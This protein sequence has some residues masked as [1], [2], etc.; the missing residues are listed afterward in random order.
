MPKEKAERQELTP[1]LRKK[2]EAIQEVQ[3]QLGAL[4]QEIGV[5]N[6]NTGKD[7]E[8]PQPITEMSVLNELQTAWSNAYLAHEGADSS[9]LKGFEKWKSF[10]Q[11]MGGEAA[12]SGIT[13]LLKALADAPSE[14]EQQATDAALRFE[15]SQLSDEMNA[16]QKYLDTFPAA[17]LSERAE[18]QVDKILG[19]LPPEAQEF[20]R[21]I[22]FDFLASIGESFNMLDFS[23]SLRF[24]MAM[25]QA[26]GDT[27]SLEKLKPEEREEVLKASVD[28]VVRSGLESKWKAEHRRWVQ[29]RKVFESNNPGKKYVV[30]PPTIFDVYKKPEPSKP[31]AESALAGN[32]KPSEVSSPAKDQTPPVNPPPPKA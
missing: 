14:K 5:R 11:A 19:K 1:E 29:E 25:E 21:A 31:P 17:P 12:T 6:R 22:I 16:G 13:D 27:A 28:P 32:Q 30:P 15:I 20:L 3:S 4:R 9:K 10:E 8:N 2:K 24:R 23:G 26:K 18:E 7:K